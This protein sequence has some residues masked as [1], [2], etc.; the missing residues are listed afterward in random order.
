[1]TLRAHAYLSTSS[2]VCSR[3]S[4][5]TRGNGR[6]AAVPLGVLSRLQGGQEHFL[7]SYSGNLSRGH[8]H[9]LGRLD[10]SGSGSGGGKDENMRFGRSGGSGSGDKGENFGENMGVRSVAP[11]PS[12]SCT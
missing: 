1:M 7:K 11:T 3:H 9:G 6:S 2:L 4:F 12:W 5:R 10:G 8:S